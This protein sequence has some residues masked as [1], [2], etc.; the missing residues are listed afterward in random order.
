MVPTGTQSLTPLSTGPSYHL[1]HEKNNYLFSINWIHPVG[2]KTWPA[3]MKP[4]VCCFFPKDHLRPLLPG[5]IKLYDDHQVVDQ[6]AGTANTVAIAAP[7]RNEDEMQIDAVPTVL[8]TPM[9]SQRA[10]F[11]QVHT[12][13]SSVLVISSLGHSQPL[14]S[15]ASSSSSSSSIKKSNQI[16]TRIVR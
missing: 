14:A 7:V 2:E 11:A 12:A 1:P 6:V 4:H 13:G 9:I 16:I 10:A 8:E 3:D 15:L 5:L